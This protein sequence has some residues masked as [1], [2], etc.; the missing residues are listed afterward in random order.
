[1]GHCFFHL[2]MP[3]TSSL[4]KWHGW[5]CGIYVIKLCE[6][7]QYHLVCDNTYSI[8]LHCLTADCFS[9]NFLLKLFKILYLV[10]VLITY[11]TYITNLDIF[12][13]SCQV[14]SVFI[15]LIM[16]SS[17]LIIV[18]HAKFTKINWLLT[19]FRCL[20]LLSLDLTKDSE[21]WLSINECVYLREFCI[22]DMKAC[23]LS[24][25]I[26]FEAVYR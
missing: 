19:K 3:I 26:N 22:Q 5:T 20:F 8:E 13:L 16:F 2:S 7:I 15:Y 10:R 25:S 18:I 24:T 1:M 11:I 4:S 9:L 12:I 21:S 14:H 17:S 6:I 23:V